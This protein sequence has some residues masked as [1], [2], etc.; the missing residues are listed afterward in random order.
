[1]SDT[2]SG[3][4]TARLARLQDN[5]VNADLSCPPLTN[6]T[7]GVV[8][9]L[10][11]PKKRPV[12]VSS[13]P[14]SNGTTSRPLSSAS[15]GYGSSRA[16]IES[17]SPSPHPLPQV[18]NEHPPTDVKSTQDFAIPKANVIESSLLWSYLKRPK[19]SRPTILLLD[20][21]PKEDYDRGCLN[22]E[23][24]VWMDPILLDDK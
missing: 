3:S 8:S 4:I 22:A 14:G 13:D 11:I 23:H 1:M 7:A 15:S 19:A 18:P 5:G 17:P 12:P 6:P 16:V 9:T 10:K 2:A 20:V 24:V 21:R